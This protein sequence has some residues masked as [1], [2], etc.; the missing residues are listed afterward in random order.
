MNAQHTPGPTLLEKVVAMDDAKFER[1]MRRNGYAGMAA[2]K[3]AANRRAA[4]AKATG[5]AS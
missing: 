1:W 5:S 3:L 4:I 2:V